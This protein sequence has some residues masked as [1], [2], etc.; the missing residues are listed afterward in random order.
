V[1]N[2]EDKFVSGGDGAS[3]EGAEYGE[4]VFGVGASAEIFFGT[5]VTAEKFGEALSVVGATETG[6]D[7]VVRGVDTEVAG[8]S[9]V[10]KAIVASDQLINGLKRW[11]HEY[12][13]TKS[14][15]ESRRVT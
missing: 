13:R 8:A 2:A 14:H 1:L 3:I 5:G 9:S 7:I 15:G 10:R 4:D 11:S 6:A 12:P